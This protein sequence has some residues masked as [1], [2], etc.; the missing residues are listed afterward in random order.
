LKL[1]T[2]FKNRN[3]KLELLNSFQKLIFF[4]KVPPAAPRAPLLRHWLRGPSEKVLISRFVER[5]QKTRLQC[6]ASAMPKPAMPSGHQELW[7]AQ[8]FW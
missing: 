5:E 2:L 7:N 1:K 6:L 3:E 8:S 4:S